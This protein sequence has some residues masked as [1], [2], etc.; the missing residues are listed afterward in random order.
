MA[1]VHFIPLHKHPYYVA[2][3]NC[4]CSDFPVSESV[5]ER[6]ISLPIYPGMSNA[7]VQQV[8]YSVGD[9]LQRFRA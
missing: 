9:V 8:I 2:A 5:Y 7:D 6:I 4:D 3:F 1:S